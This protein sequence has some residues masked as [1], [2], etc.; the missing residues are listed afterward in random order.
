MAARATDSA[1]ITFGL[2]AIPV[3]LF[4]GTRSGRSI[5]FN[6][7]HEGCGTRVRRQY[8]CP[9]DEEVLDSDDLVKG[10]EFAKG[11]YV[12]FSDEELKAVEEEASHAIEITEFV[13]LDAVDPVYY[14]RPYYLGPDK[15]G[16][17]PYQLLRQ[18]MLETGLA[19]IARYAAR[20][21]QYLVML[22]PADGGIALQQLHYA[23]EVRDIS[24]VP[25]GEAREPKKEELD[26]AR[27]LVEQYANEEFQPGKYD[28]AVRQR[29]EEI[30]QAKV[31]GKEITAAPAE[32]PRAEVIDIMDALKKSLG[33]EGGKRAEPRRAGGKGGRK[34]ARKASR[35]SSSKKSAKK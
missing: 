3:K 28:D 26:L 23:D 29:L 12:T 33:E 16:D 8:Y 24:E 30:I 14:D 21:K 17:R 25:L 2:V 7:L 11:Q 18:V 32:A 5:R 4:T 34:A 19:A 22:R 1:T 6:L 9:K 20:G 10:Y 27:R 13:P 15:G 35:R 31:E